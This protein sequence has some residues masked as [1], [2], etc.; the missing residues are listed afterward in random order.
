M[1]EMLNLMTICRLI[2]QR[3]VES[4]F[5][6]IFDPNQNGYSGVFSVQAVND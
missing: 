6:N 3:T 5:K 1:T 4:V 2:S